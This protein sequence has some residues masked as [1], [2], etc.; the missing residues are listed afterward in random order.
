MTDIPS[1]PKSAKP[2]PSSAVVGNDLL[3]LAN[4][5]PGQIALASSAALIIQRHFRGFLGRRLYAARL[6]EVFA[7]EEEKQ[8]KEREKNLIEETEIL[9][10][11][12]KALIDMEELETVRY[13]IGPASC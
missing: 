3:S 5:S 1:S 11:A 6:W 9:V 7:E 12:S 13:T 2:S 4:S 10:E 8:R